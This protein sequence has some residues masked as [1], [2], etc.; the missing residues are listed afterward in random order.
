MPANKLK[1]TIDDEVKSL[2]K[3]AG[4]EDAVC[5]DMNYMIFNYGKFHNNFVN[6]VIHIICVPL[7]LYSWY[8]MLS[9]IAPYYELG[10]E[11]TILGGSRIGCGIVPQ[12]IVSVLYFFIDFKIALGVNA[13]WWP[14]MMLGNMHWMAYKDMEYPLGLNQF[15]FMTL[16]NISSWIA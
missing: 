2:S 16:I 14:T 5:V 8:I 4:A 13:W 15:W 7:I 3:K 6:Q 12:I 1:K 11:V 9:F 10:A